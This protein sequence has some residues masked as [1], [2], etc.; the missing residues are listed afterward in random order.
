MGIK[1][2][3]NELW[4]KLARWRKRGAFEEQMS[5]NETKVLII[6]R[7]LSALESCV[8]CLSDG[9]YLVSTVMDS[10][11]GLQIVKEFQ[12]DLVVVDLDTDGVPGFQVIERIHEFDPTIIQIATAWST[13]VSSTVEAIRKGAFEYLPKPYSKD[14]LQIAA[15]R[16]IEHRRLIQEAA[17]LRREREM[18]REQF[19]A[20]V[21]HELKSPL[22]SVLQ[23][24]YALEHDL[25]ANLS[26]DHVA[27]IGR[28]KGSINHLLD[29]I[30][31]WLNVI[32]GGGDINK[33]R[34]NFKPVSIPE[35]IAKA[36]ESVESH[37]VRKDIEIA[38]SIDDKAGFVHGDM[39]TLCEALVNLIGNAIKYTRMG[40]RIHVKATREGETIAIAV[41]DRGVGISKEDLPFIFGDFYVGKSAPVAE[42]G[43]GLGLAITRRI[44]EA[45][46]GSI[47]VESALDKGSTFIIRLPAFKAGPSGEPQKPAARSARKRQ[48]ES[49]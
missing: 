35:V 39:V 36:I 17:S 27:R 33:I 16:A 6:D 1:E 10:A 20:I 5:Q 7:E 21:S 31:S 18:L 47:S 34:E 40:S 12:P 2:T 42:R 46:G 23:N 4:R 22:G 43:T 24:L 32:S 26:E 29:L 9:P 25:A 37:A 19:A 15:Q 11:F 48:G 41:M 3:V 49:K 28:M 14:E 44:V 38:P 13:T 45:H 30:R 8:D